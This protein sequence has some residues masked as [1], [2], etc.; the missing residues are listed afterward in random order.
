[1]SERYPEVFEGDW[2]DSNQHSYNF[3]KKWKSYSSIY[4][5]AGGDI[6][7]FDEVVSQPLEKCLLYLAYINDKAHLEQL[8]HRESIAKMK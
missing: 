5:L 1:L 4:T 7:K 8:M 2:G 3:G 6:T